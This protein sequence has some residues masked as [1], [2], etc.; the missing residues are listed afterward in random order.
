MIRRILPFLLA[1][2]LSLGAAQAQKNAPTDDAIYDQVRRILANDPD[3]KGGAFDVEV[4]SG[5]V[6]VKGKVANEKA[7]V[8][9]DKLCRK[10]KGVTEVKNLVKVEP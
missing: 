3:V 8:K 6:T 5:T 4:K 10:A 1:L 7:R 2:I 9:V